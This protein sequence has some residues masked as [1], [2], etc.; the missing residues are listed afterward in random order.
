LGSPRVTIVVNPAAGRGRG[1]RLI[2]RLEHLLA[3]LLRNSCAGIFNR[4][5]NVS[6]TAVGLGYFAYNS[7]ASS[8][9]RGFDGIRDEPHESLL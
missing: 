7:Y 4:H 6:F 9:R 1:V 2:P 8:L 3:I 5:L